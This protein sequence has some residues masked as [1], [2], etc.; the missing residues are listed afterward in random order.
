MKV[1]GLEGVKKEM[2]RITAQAEAYRKG[3]AMLR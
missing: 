3:G 2:D 1:V